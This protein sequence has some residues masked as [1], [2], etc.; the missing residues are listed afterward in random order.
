[1]SQTDDGL[2]PIDPDA[3][4]P[5][6]T[7]DL[8][9]DEPEPEQD[10][11]DKI[12]TDLDPRV[13][14]DF[15]GL[16]YLGK[17]E[18]ECKVAGHTFLLRTPTQPERL[19]LGSLLKPYMNTPTVEKAYRLVQVAMFVHRIDSEWAPVP[20]TERD[21]GLA[22]RFSWILNSI[23]AEAVIERLYDAAMGLELRSRAVVDEMD[24]LGEP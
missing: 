2:L 4:G 21:T 8:A 20:L 18:E 24:R 23:T 14:E 11:I 6:F 12:K 17:L 5:I 1:M 9:A 3:V 15:V 22:A 16:L 13:R 10:P 7:M 19:E